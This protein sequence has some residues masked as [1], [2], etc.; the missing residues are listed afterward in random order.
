M[1]DDHPECPRDRR[2]AYWSR[3]RYTLDNRAQLA[4]TTRAQSSV[5]VPLPEICFGNN[6][7]TVSHPALDFRYTFKGIDALQAVDATGEEPGSGFVKVAYAAEWAKT[8]DLE[9]SNVKV[10][11]KW[12]W[13]YTTTHPGRLDISS[14]SSIVR[15]F[16][17]RPCRDLKES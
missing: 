1:Q 17:R 15:L 10:V 2:V 4:S 9:G 13:T 14:D 11:K 8:R 6:H 5:D 12:D 16:C 7:L 3:P